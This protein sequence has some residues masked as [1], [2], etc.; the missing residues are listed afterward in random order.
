MEDF[1]SETDS[2]Y[3]SYW[4]DWVSWINVSFR[5]SG[6]LLDNAVM[7]SIASDVMTE[8]ESSG[9]AASCTD[10]AGLSLRGQLCQAYS[11]RPHE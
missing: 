1:N 11:F 5:L 6:L 4:R 2:D 8:A 10:V 3:T 7:G 9:C